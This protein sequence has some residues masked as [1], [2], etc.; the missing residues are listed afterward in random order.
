MARAPARRARVE[1]FHAREDEGEELAG[2]LRAAGYDARLHRSA[3]GASVREL[4]RRS[5]EA[6]VVDLSRLPSQGRQI[7]VLLRQQAWSRS[8]PIVFAGGAPEKLAT[9]R[10]VLPDATYAAAKELP[11]ALRRALAA[12]L[13]DPVVPSS[14]GGYSGTPLAAKLGVK[15]ASTLRLVG[16]PAGFAAALEPLPDGARVVAR[17]TRGAE[18]VLLFCRD[19]AELARRFDAA[20][21]ELAERG[22]IWIAWPKK[23][24]AL[25]G[26]L[27]E[28][29]V[30]AFG[31]ARGWVDYK[32]CAIDGTW[33]GLCFSRRR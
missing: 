3:S 25:E 9:L 4:R 20:V 24:S 5:P 14:I 32:V 23:G 19:H 30:R 10:A 33:S 21:A 26:D 18:R 2:A 22:S 11:R 16:A 27:R 29:E 8:I 17:A 7:A 28:P 13:A 6:V 15:P 31:L 12:P 1:V